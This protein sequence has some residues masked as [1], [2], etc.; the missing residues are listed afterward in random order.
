MATPR[1]ILCCPKCK[2]PV[3]AR[4]FL[5][6]PAMVGFLDSVLPTFSCRCGYKGLP[7]KLGLKEYAKWVG[8]ATKP[9][10]R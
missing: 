8:K 2:K 3:E 5:A 1:S 4:D 7:I 6:N 9:A 10:K